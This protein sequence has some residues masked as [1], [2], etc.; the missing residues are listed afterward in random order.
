MG[1]QLDIVVTCT[2]RKVLSSSDGLRVRDLPVD[3]SGWPS[4]EVWLDR[5]RGNEG[6]TRVARELY[7]GEAW[8]VSLELERLARQ[9]RPVRMWVLSAG[10][11][12]ICFDSELAPY[13]ATFSATSSDFVGGKLQGREASRAAQEW[14]Q[15]LCSASRAWSRRKSLEDVAVK[16][17]GD[18]LMVLSNA[19]LRACR[20]DVVRA[21]SRNKR[22]VVLSPSA[23]NS[24]AIRHASPLFDARLLTTQEDRR[25]GIER[26]IPEGSRMSL[27]GRVAKLLVEHF[28]DRTIDRAEAFSLLHRLTEAQPPL[29]TYDRDDRSDEAVRHFIRQR[30]LDDP[31]LTKTRLLREFR[32]AGNRCEQKR[33]GRLFA[34]VSDQLDLAESA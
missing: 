26:P 25:R 22:L 13:S 14:W 2:D 21:V 33:F 16:A 30:L 34:G 19:Y 4:L 32:D 8:S 12:V 23:H 5:V 24:A 1:E 11:G 20:R 18:V 3:R 9:S 17:P 31:G 15:G 7:Q 10:Y 27:N 6:P 29:A 28:G